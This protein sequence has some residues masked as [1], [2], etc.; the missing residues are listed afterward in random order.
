MP[1]RIPRKP[2]PAVLV[3]ALNVARSTWP[4]IAA[5]RLVLLCHAWAT[6]T[7]HHTI[8][9]FD[10]KA[11]NGRGGDA[12]NPKLTVVGTDKETA[13]DWIER[14]ARRFASE[15][16]SYWLVTSDRAL[17]AQAGLKAKRTIGGG[18][19][20]RELMALKSDVL[21]AQPTF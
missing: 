3:D 9:V 13:D 20:A 8:V 12:V 1:A 21:G 17:R 19:F 16:L 10:G 2:S 5:D 18:A 15:G 11:P 14:E 7:G 6:T 4:N